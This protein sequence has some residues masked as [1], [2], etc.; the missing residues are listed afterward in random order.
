VI[1]AVKAFWVGVAM[2][3]VMVTAPVAPERLIPAPAPK[4][5]TPELATVSVDPEGEIVTPEPPATVSAP[6]RVLRDVTPAPA[7][8]AAMVTPPEPGV[9]VT[10]VPAVSPK[11]PEVGVIVLMVLT[12]VFVIVIW[13]VLLFVDTLTPSE[14]VM[15]ISVLTPLI[16]STVVCPT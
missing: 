6:V 4:L 7:D 3:L 11:L 13:L 15:L 9:I 12:P 14:P 16:L 8:G 5:V 10:P 2:V 1:T